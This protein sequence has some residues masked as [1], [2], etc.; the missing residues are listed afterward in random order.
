MGLA[1]AAV[2]LWVTFAPCF[3][4]VFAGAPYIERLQHL[5]ALKGAL[6]GVMAAVVGVIFNLTVWFGLHVFF[7]TVEPVVFGPLTLWR[8]EL[9]TIEWGAVILATV[10]ALALFVCHLSLPVMLALAAAL[11]L[12]WQLWG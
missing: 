4:W 3:L 7:Q 8:P 10:A 1:G 5:P 2:T 11:G 9:A 6:D 12:G